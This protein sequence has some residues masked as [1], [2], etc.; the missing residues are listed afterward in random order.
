MAG[1]DIEHR[2]QVERTHAERGVLHDVM[3]AER[4]QAWREKWAHRTVAVTG[5]QAVFNFKA[6][7]VADL[8]YSIINPA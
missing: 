7:V 1:M 5:D 8:G 2:L 4:L 3:N 6:S